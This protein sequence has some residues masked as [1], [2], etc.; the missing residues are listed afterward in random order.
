MG[1]AGEFLSL[2]VLCAGVRVAVYEGS[3]TSSSADGIVICIRG[4]HQSLAVVHDELMC[5]RVDAVGEVG[6]CGVRW[7]QGHSL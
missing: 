2:C 5:R 3:G 4:Q 6:D 1:D 7:R